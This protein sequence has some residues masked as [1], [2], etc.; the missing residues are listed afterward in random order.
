MPKP[1]RKQV[2]DCGLMSDYS[3]TLAMLQVVQTLDLEID[4]LQTEVEGIP[5]DLKLAREERVRLSSALAQLNATLEGVRRRVA[6][7]DQELQNRSTK[8]KRAETSEKNASASK[9]QTQYAEHARQ[10][11]LEIDELENDSLP[12]I[13]ENEALDAKHKALEAELAALLPQ[14]ERLEGVD[15][16]RIRS[17]RE[18]RLSK[19][20]ERDTLAERLDQKI[21][22]EYDNI[23]KARKGVGLSMMK[24]G[25]CTVCNAQLHL[26][27]QQKVTK[28]LEMTKCPSCG[29]ILRVM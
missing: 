12:L 1:V 29:R 9:E 15:E 5:S 19:I 2:L 7:A 18:S 21:V 23:R 13:E 27:L 28:A 25:K 16:D 3:A 17:L 4:Q 14:L 10:M 22:R 6:V 8:L 24:S 11:R 20:D 26:S